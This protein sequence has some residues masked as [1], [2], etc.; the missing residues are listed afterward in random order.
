MQQH[1]QEQSGSAYRF[2]PPEL[3]V[4]A[5]G[6]FALKASIPRSIGCDLS[7]A[8]FA[9]RDSEGRDVCR[10]DG[11]TPSDE[12]FEI[13]VDGLRA[14]VQPGIYRYTLAMASESK[15]QCGELHG[16]ALTVAVQAHALRLSTWD[17]PPAALPDGQVSF[18]IGLK[19]SSA[20]DLAGR[21][22]QVFDQDD[23]V[24]AAE[25]FSNRIWP[26]TDALHFVEVRASAPKEAGTYI[27]KVVCPHCEE[28]LPHAEA[29]TEIKLNVTRAPDCQITV[30]VVELQTEAPLANAMIVLHPFRAATNSDG[31]ARLLV[32]RG[33]YDLLV[34]CS[35]HMPS[36]TSLSVS[37]DDRLRIVL[38]PEAPWIPLEE[39]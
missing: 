22:V 32:T 30:D 20:C 1:T 34:S 23:H 24:V 8:T 6:S 12:G 27:W 4:D 31:Q 37:G 16:P 14:S 26:G 19:C 33:D 35:R 2:D 36:S 5:G 39:A 9:L 11:A 13:S 3:A 7:G 38:A 25:T 15:V 10:V 28:Q 18:K 17:V 21:M 29:T